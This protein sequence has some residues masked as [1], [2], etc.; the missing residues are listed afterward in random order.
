MKEPLYSRVASRLEEHIANGEWPPGTRL[1]PERDLCRYLVVSRDTVRLALT[2]LEG[3][4]LIQRQQGRGTFVSWPRVEADVSR[5]FTLGAALRERGYV[6]TTR[7]LRVDVF[8]A[9]RQTADVLDIAPGDAVIELERLRSVD[10]GPLLIETTHVPHQRF[11]GLEKADLTSRSLY[12]VL[13]EEFGCS[14]SSAVET[15]EPVVTTRAESE[16]LGVAR[17][18]AA[19]LVR[20]VAKDQRGQ[21]VESS[22]ALLRGDRCNFLMRRSIQQLSPDLIVRDRE[23]DPK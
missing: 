3:R 23:K 21:V 10:A 9:S 8:Q 14:V 12:A 13:H 6:L 4:G 19:L 5:F 1:P 22:Q 18:A 15:F 7:A 16:L 20:R 17:H 11:A 2:E